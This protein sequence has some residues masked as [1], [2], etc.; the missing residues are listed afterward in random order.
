MSDLVWWTLFVVLTLLL[1][2]LVGKLCYRVI[3]DVWCSGTELPDD[4]QDL[5]D[6]T[7]YRN[8]FRTIF[9]QSQVNDESDKLMMTKEFHFKSDQNGTTPTMTT[10]GGKDKEEQ[11]HA[12]VEEDESKSNE[13]NDKV[14]EDKKSNEDEKVQ[15]EASKQKDEEKVQIEEV[16]EEKDEENIEIEEVLNEQKSR[17]DKKTKDVV[18]G[19]PLGILTLEEMGILNQIQAIQN[20]TDMYAKQIP[21]CPGGR[22]HLTY[23]DINEKFLMN[24]IGLSSI[25]CKENDKLKRR[26]QMVSLYIQECQN[27]LKKRADTDVL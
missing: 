19:E 21:F 18:D 6:L 20:Q 3:S 10:F 24:L 14:D 8:D 23:F 4:A 16:P 22:N 17:L 26:K 13:T 5:E 15:T 27:E 1:V 11:M 7:R 2:V 9:K 25:D 12:I